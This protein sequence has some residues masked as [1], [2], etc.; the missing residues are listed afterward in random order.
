[1]L[2]MWRLALVSGEPMT[3]PVEVTTRYSTTV[4][5]LP[6]AWAFV[7]AR[8]ALLR[9][10]RIGKPGSAKLRDLQLVDA[11]GRTTLLGEAVLHY[12]PGS[13]S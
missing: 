2:E 3:A 11:D 4:P 13:E 7:M 10:D 12:R 9:D 1:M 5:D 8:V 6:G